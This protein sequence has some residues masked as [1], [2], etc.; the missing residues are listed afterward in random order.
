M[1]VTVE[2]LN[3]VKKTLHI[4]IPEDKVTRELDKAYQNLKKRAKIKGFRPG[5]IPRSVLERYFK[6]D[7]DADVSSRLIQESFADVMKEKDLKIIGTPKIDPHELD[8]KSP[9]RYDA[10]VELN[11]EIED[12]D[13]RGLT[14]NKTRYQVGDQEIDAQLKLHQKNLAQ[15]RT[16]EEIRPVKEGDHV[17]MD[18]EGFKDGKPFPETG[19]TENYSMKL[20]DGSVLKSFDENL[21]GMK[22]GDKKEIVI[23]YPEDHQD[24]KLAGLE[25]SYQVT[26]KEIRE[27]VLPEI[28]DEFAKDLGKYETLEEVKNAIRDNLK[29]GY[30]T[31]VQHEL[32]EQI[33]D[34]L[35]EKKNFEVPDTLVDHQLNSI[36]AET[37]GSFAYQNLSMEDMGLTKEQLS[38]KYRDIALKRVK[39]Y[40]I[41]RKLIEQENLKLSEEEIENGFVE[42]SENL[43][44]PLDQIKDFYK[45][46][47]DKFN[48]Y[49]H[50]LLEKKAIELIIDYSK[51]VDVEPETNQ[52]GES[53]TDTSA[54]VEA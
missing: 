34:T 46:N 45:Q 5:K 1:Q 54:G 22:P 40:L 21:I 17:L 7:V 26:L 29:R 38:A 12:I 4:E 31:S 9:F 48:I 19:R 6:K 53:E 25:I 35:I 11:P 10:T 20:G 47:E 51:I 15:Q 14:L 49:K 43:Q 16:I 27:E 8:G 36:I 41:V 32:N 3:S 28:D 33:F 50:S 42:M 44:R 37:E 18:Y 2:D 23:D 52:K 24:K 13:F 30:N 39:R